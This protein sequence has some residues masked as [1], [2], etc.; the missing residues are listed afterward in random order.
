MSN[1]NLALL[2]AS[3]YGEFPEINNRNKINESLRAK[4][5]LSDEQARN[6]IDNYDILAHQP[7]C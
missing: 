2:A 3:A 4:S 5:E 6:F 1:D 7:N